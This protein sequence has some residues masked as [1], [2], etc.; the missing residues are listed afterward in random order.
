MPNYTLNPSGTVTIN[1][2]P[3]TVTAAA[4]SRTYDG[5][6]TAATPA[7]L[8][9]GAIQTGDTAPTWT[10][11]YDNRNVGTGK[12]LTPAALTVSDGNGGDNYS[13]TYTPQDSGVINAMNLTVTAAAN[14]KPYDGET[15]AAA[16]AT[17]TA[18]SIQPGDSAPTWTETYDNRER[19]HRQDADPGATDGVRR[20]RR[21]QLQLHLHAAKQWCD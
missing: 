9:S 7:T 17:I 16:Y 8:T 4:N 1:Q 15:T 6:T 3:L 10:Q 19:G 12:T 21:Q 18:G 2:Y 14:T 5:G 13:Y 11:T 20:Q